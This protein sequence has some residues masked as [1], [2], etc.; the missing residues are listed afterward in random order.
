MEEQLARPFCR[1][2]DAEVLDAIGKHGLRNDALMAI[3]PTM[4]TSQ[5]A[6]NVSG[7]IE[8]VRDFGDSGGAP[9]SYAER[10]FR[11]LRGPGALPSFFVSGRDVA[12]QERFAMHA[13]IQRHVD[14]PL[15]SVINCPPELSLEDFEQLCVGAYAIGASGC[16][17][18]GAG[19]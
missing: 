5:L 11:E 17:F 14:A 7:G 9:A 1:G 2:L 15:G 10:R 18:F 6:D 16:A 4:A 19:R 13:A 8:P 3:A 12:P